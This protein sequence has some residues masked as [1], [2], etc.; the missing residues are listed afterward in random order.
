MRKKTGKYSEDSSLRSQAE[1]IL[2]ELDASPQPADSEPNT[3]KLLHELQVHQ[4]ELEMQNEELRQTRDSLEAVLAQYTELYDFSPVGYFTLDG[5]GKILRTNF[6]GAK[7]LGIERSVVAGREFRLFASAQDKDGWTGFFNQ[8]LTAQ[9]KLTRELSLETQQGRLHVLAEGLGDGSGLECWLALVDIT[10]RKHAEEKARKSQQHVMNILEN[11]TD[12]FFETDRKFT[13]TYMNRK[14]EKPLFTTREKLLGKNLWEAFPEAVGGVFHQQYHRALELQ[15]PV[16]F[17]AYYPPFAMWYE[18][19]AYPTPVSL[20]VY[21]RDITERK[22]LEDSL[23]I[24]EQ[25]YR[26]IVEMQNELVCRYLSDGRLTF[27]NEAYLR[28]YGL[29]RELTLGSNFVPRIPREDQDAIRA[30]LKSLTPL[31][32]SV[33]LTHRIMTAEGEIRWQKWTHRAL[34]SPE[35]EVLEYQAVGDDI[36]ERM[37]AEELRDQIERIIRHDLRTPACNAIGIARMLRDEMNLTG[38]QRDLLGLIEHAGQNM[39]D[40]LDSSLDLYKIETGQY[41]SEPEVFDS[42]SMLRGIIGALTK[43]AQFAE[44][45]LELF[46]NRHSHNPDSPCLCLGE[47]KL[48]RTALQNLLVNALEASPPD[49]EVVVEL[50]LDTDCRIEIINQG[51]VPQDIRASFFDKYVTKGKKTGHG[52]GTYSAKLMVNAQGGIIELDT[53]KKGR[54]SVTVRVPVHQAQAVQSGGPQA[55]TVAAGPG[56]AILLVEDDKVAQAYLRYLLEEDGHQVKMA[57]DGATA[58]SILA[59][60]QFD[61]VLMD[62]EMPVMDGAE[63]T[64]RIR[65]SGAPQAGVPVIAMTAGVMAGDREKCLAAGMND[66]IAKPVELEA[67]REVTRRVLGAGPTQ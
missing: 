58:L 51:A 30:A 49:A 10:K 39:L 64:R 43:K 22:N 54:T 5:G 20:S 14:A 7:L 12:A 56:L 3:L 2:F 13:V 24:S 46:V 45:R 62:V 33:D 25:R 37:R 52:L 59:E 55:K 21:F 42:V 35:G 57:S 15:K 18:C 63:A 50:S 38:E 36:T 27:V 67:L 19:H 17:E 8:I 28:Y 6:A 31:A 66:Y 16:S 26:D 29:K 60:R 40:T 61:L 65:A 47:P 48:L 34:F 53:S 23:R 11:T 9:T 44:N 32:S 4:V 41:R 1:W